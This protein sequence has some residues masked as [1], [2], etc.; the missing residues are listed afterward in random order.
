MSRSGDY[1]GDIPCETAEQV[2]RRKSVIFLGHIFATRNIE[3]YFNN[4][5]EKVELWE[6]Y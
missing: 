3:A 4:V 5:A 2:M 6:G 1:V